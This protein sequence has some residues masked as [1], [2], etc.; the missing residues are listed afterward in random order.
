MPMVPCQWS[1]IHIF[2]E[3]YTLSMPIMIKWHVKHHQV[4]ERQHKVCLGGLYR[5]RTG[6]KSTLI[7]RTVLKSP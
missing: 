6:L 2:E 4:G 1:S 3:E 7:Y 5:V